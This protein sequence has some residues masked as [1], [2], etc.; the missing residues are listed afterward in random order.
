MVGNSKVAQPKQTHITSDIQLEITQSITLKTY[1][2]Q[3][4]IRGNIYLALIIEF[5]VN[6][7]FDRDEVVYHE[8]WN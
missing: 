3:N 2:S 1:K 6:P 5:D 8:F 7:F 4:C